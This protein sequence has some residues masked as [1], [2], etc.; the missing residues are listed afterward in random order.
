MCE[1]ADHSP[2][3]TAIDGDSE[4]GFAEV[5]D[6]F[7]YLDGDMPMLVVKTRTKW[8]KSLNLIR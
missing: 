4:S 7:L 8:G 1:D 6:C 2:E 5:R 3:K